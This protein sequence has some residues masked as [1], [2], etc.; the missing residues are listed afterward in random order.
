LPLQDRRNYLKKLYP[1]WEKKTIYQRF[2]EAASACPDRILYQ[3]DRLSAS[4]QQTA[5]LTD[6]AAAA[7]Y[8]LGIRKGDR[9]AVN[10]NNTL[11]YLWITFALARIGAVKVPINRRITLDQKCFVIKDTGAEIFVTDKPDDVSC[12]KACGCLKKVIMMGESEA[13][14]SYVSS[15]RDLL[16]EAGGAEMP[17]YPGPSA[18]DLSDI[19]YTSGSTGDPKG[20]MLTHDM[21]LRSA[22]ANCLNRGFE[23]GRKVMIT[24]PLFHVYG[25][26]EGL[27]AILFVGGTLVCM[28]GRFNEGK[29]LR[30]IQDMKVNDILCVPSVMEKILGEQ[31]L[32][33]CDISSL[34]AVYCSASVCPDWLWGSIA[35]DL[36]VSEIVT[37]YGMSEV[38][39]ASV[40]SPPEAPLKKLCSSV[41]KVLTDYFTDCEKLIEYRVADPESLRELPAGESG[42]LICRGAIVTGGYYNNK[43]ASARIFTED[44]W[45]RTGDIASA[46]SGGYITFCGRLNENYKINGENVSPLFVD[47]IISDCK[48]VAQAETV[49]VPDE[50]LGWVGVAFIEPVNYCYVTKER[51]M[52]YCSEH[53]A[54]YQMPKY[55]FFISSEKWPRT[56]NGKITKKLLREQAVRDLSLMKKKGEEKT[57]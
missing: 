49:G 32:R 57:G 22:F 45:L 20:V 25:Y 7:F 41:G 56:A 19:I 26:I 51:I 10:L 12:A 4:Y 27:L 9:V 14:G 31:Q 1:V 29:T 44:G 52:G 33:P 23:D 50:K 2:A 48:E 11:E 36:G 21:M 8:H 13:Y 34:Y 38:S 42:E 18:D 17:Q 54:S 53:L 3:D 55:F 5:E 43:E 37:G 35:S 15:W 47:R 30:M 46:D 40:Q 24:V 16:A 28:Q 39:G 6:E